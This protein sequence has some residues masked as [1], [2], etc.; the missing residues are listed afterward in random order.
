LRFLVISD[1]H[2]N[3][4]ALRAVLRFVAR[5]RVGGIIALGDLVGYGGRPN[6][7]LDLLRQT[8]R[9]K[10]YIR[11]NHDRVATGVSEP[12]DFNG[13]AREAILWTRERLSS[14]N[15]GFLRSLPSGPLEPKPGLLVCHGSPDDEDEYVLSTMQAGRIFETWSSSVMFFGHTHLPIAYRYRD[16]EVDE[17]YVE[18]QNTVQLESGYRYLINPGSVGQPR[19]RD[20]RTSF[21]IWDDVN[22]SVRFYRIAYDV[23]SAQRNILREG[24]PPILAYRLDAGF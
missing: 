11:G 3:L 8:P 19:D 21:L 20:W 1:V 24:L 23:G 13:P 15:L 2:S 5:K 12:E 14:A 17:V 10:I 22:R 18:D 6:H 4:E 7:V 16:G 9:S